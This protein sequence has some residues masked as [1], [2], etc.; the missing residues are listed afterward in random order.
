MNVQLELLLQIQDLKSQRRELTEADAGRAVEE[1][2]F[3][4]DVGA[5]LDD[6][7]ATIAEV[8]EQL[9][10]AIRERYLQLCRGR[11]RAVVPGINGTCYG[12]FVSIP[13]AVASDVSSNQELQ[14]CDNCGRF[15]Y[16]IGP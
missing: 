8:E 9:A 6:L 1:E 11:D 2:E 3:N 5:A 7:D 13:T 12:C 4:V 14:Q 15:L 10:P 16:V